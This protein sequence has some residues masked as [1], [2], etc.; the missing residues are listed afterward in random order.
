MFLHVKK[1]YIKRR[2]I[3]KQILKLIRAMY[4]ISISQKI[5]C[6]NIFENVF[7]T[8]G[9]VFSL[10]YFVPKNKKWLL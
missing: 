7:F 1:P 5:I 10:L 8:F 4:S 2:V 9:S 3:L 6:K